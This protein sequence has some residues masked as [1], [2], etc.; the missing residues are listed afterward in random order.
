MEKAHCL[1]RLLITITVNLSVTRKVALINSQ[2][3]EKTYSIHSRIALQ[4]REYL[5]EYAS[6][7]SPAQLFCHLMHTFSAVLLITPL[8]NTESATPTYCITSRQGV[9]G[10]AYGLLVGREKLSKQV[11]V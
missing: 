8:F 3:V 6:I 2:S 4:L 11:C 9:S 10:G 5:A 1:C 7:I